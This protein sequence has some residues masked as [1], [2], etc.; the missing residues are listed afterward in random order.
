MKPKSKKLSRVLIG[1]FLAGAVCL[2]LPVSYLSLGYLSD[3]TISHG[4]EV[5]VKNFSPGTKVSYEVFSDGVA[6][7]KAESKV[8][9]SGY[10]LLDVPPAVKS[11]PSDVITYKMHIDPA[12]DNS[13]GDHMLDLLLKVNQANGTAAYS[14]S[15][16]NEFSKILVSDGQKTEETKADWAGFFAGTNIDSNLNEDNKKLLKLAFQSYNVANDA[17]SGFQNE[18]VVEVVFGDPSGSSAAAVQARYTKALAMMTEQ[19]S[20]VMMQQVE[21]IGA[22]LDAKMQLETERKQQEL[23]ARAHKDYHPSEQV[24][25]FGSF[26]KSLANTESKSETDKRALNK[27]LMNRILG[28]QDISSA[29]GPNIDIPARLQHFS[30]IY[31]NPR[32]NNDGLDQLCSTLTA[33]TPVQRE[34]FNKDVDFFR[35][36]EGKLT[37]N[38]NFVDGSLTNDEEDIIALAENLYMPESYGI[39]SE[40]DLIGTS[41]TSNVYNQLH[42][43]ALAQ[44]YNSRSFA[45]RL[46][47]AQNSFINIVG[48]KSS[49]PAGVATA[50]VGA[51]PP[52]II[53]PPPPATALTEDTGWSFM[54]SLMREFGVAD[55]EIQ[56]YLGERPSYYAQMEVMT[57]KIYQSPNFYTN[58]YD[59]P[60]NVDRIGASIDAITLMSQRDRFESSLRRE[61]LTSLLIEDALKDQ[62]DDV[63]SRIY[64]NMSKPQ[65]KV[66]P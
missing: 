49:A 11:Q 37:L 42:S 5:R 1:S 26:V 3:A 10:A 44:H 43:G 7:A 58:L 36:L 31:C 16:V 8:D 23:M 57:K 19:L 18:G 22:F 14:G 45:A 30:T 56:Q 54:K 62:V 41:D 25:R 47:V 39:I 27:I 13:S 64:S 15:G 33:A 59:K 17:E 35:T 66:E 60:A 53:A 21:I 40:A 34:R 6:V 65:Y 20:A 51:W 50:A 52:N 48:M 4:T 24:C 38:T 32:D 9:S 29:E 46:N 55:A 63:T 12:I 61:M 2:A 28:F